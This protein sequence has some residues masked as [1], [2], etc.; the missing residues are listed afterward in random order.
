M[1]HRQVVLSSLL[2]L[3]FAL[4]CHAS[5]GQTSTPNERYRQISRLMAQ[6]D[7]EQAITDS[8]AL[9][10]EFPN[11]HDGYLALALVS[12]EADQAET[13]R[14]WLESLLA[15]MPALPMAYVGLAL[16]CSEKK[17]FAGAIEHYHNYLKQLPDDLEVVALLAVDYLNQKNGAAAEAYFKTL[18][19]A[20]PD[21]ATG[22]QGLGVLYAFL[23]RRADA[24]AEFD[25]VIALRPRSASSYSYKGYVLSNDGRYSEAIEMLSVCLPLLQANPDDVIERRVLNQMGDVY[26]RS[27]NYAEA[28]KTLDRLLALTRAGG[29]LRGEES[30]LAQIASLHY[31]QG[32]YLEALDYWRQALAVSKQVTSRKLK[33]KSYPQRHLG[34]IGDV[35]DRLGDL[36]AAEQSYLE[37][38]TLSVEARDEKN[39]SSVLKSLGDLYVEQGKL[40]QARAAAEQAL[41]LGEKVA[42]IP[43]QL[44]ALN[45][46][47]ALHRQMGDAPKAM[48][49]VQR[50]LKILDGRTDPLWLT[51]SQNNLGLVYLRS[52][53]N[54]R[55]LSAFEQTLAMDRNIVTPHAIWEA[56]SGAAAAN[57]ELGQLDQARQHYERAVE[58]MENVRARLGSEEDKAGYFADKIV[59]YKR[60]VSLLLKPRG[61][62]TNS[63]NIAAAFHNVERA[64]ARAFLDLL[65]EARVQVEQ[66]ATPDLLKRRQELQQRVSQ[67]TAQLIKE[68]APEIDKQNKAKVVELEKGLAQADAELL[69]WLRELRRRNPRYAALKYPEPITLAETQRM[70]DDKTVLLSYSL[71]ESES[72]LFAVSRNDFLVKRLPAEKTISAEVQ[73][74][75]AAITDKNNPAPLAY[76]RHATS[77]SQQLLQPASRMLTGKK[78]LIIVADGALHRLP[79]E[80]LFQPNA[81]LRGDLRELPYL[82]RQFAISYA[83]S[84]SVLAQLQKESHESAPKSFIAFGDPTYQQSDADAVP[85]TL[86][87]ANAGRLNFQPLAYSHSEVDGIAQLFARTDREVFLQDAATEE[88][89]K[90]PERLSSYRMVHFS[91]HGYVNEARPR[92]SG[93]VLSLSAQASPNKT[94][95]QSPISN[96]PSEDGLLAAYEI[97]NLKLNADLVVLSACE[98]GLGKEVKGEGL[99]SL[100]RAFMYAGAPSVVVS[101]W[102]VNDESAADLMIRFYRHLQAGK[103]KS[104]ALRQAQLETIKDNGFPFFWAPFVLVGKP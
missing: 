93:L 63:Q 69:E 28:G 56:H 53:E 41:A 19:T 96:P 52:G 31:R 91:T 73:E 44:G 86:R 49:Y 95:P 8:K 83:P 82:I 29:D 66:N 21:S 78:T 38:L 100:T 74:L 60:L 71:A 81:P 12:I 68:R 70:L 75:L 42:N 16:I 22:H 3:F 85:V 9:I 90:A 51:E 23:D 58:M 39:Q 43:N 11:Y 55:A 79:F 2:F 5:L 80:V 101:L 46:L 54:T 34:S 50:A 30:A 6:Q 64:R 4:F 89:V 7:Y 17:D 76:R 103:S 94:N 33:F 10:E 27:G 47:S 35:Q 62:Q 45:S 26:R 72:F 20:R 97:F 18:L 67:L 88:N 25:Q 84:A 99:M 61:N 87:A 14:A 37:A 36:A 15:R 24:L 65:A 59:I 32:T 77:L 98:T 40:G 57:I 48:R 92:F 13:T 1:K 104:E 102:N